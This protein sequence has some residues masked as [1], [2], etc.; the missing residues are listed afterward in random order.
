M[1]AIQ[2]F[3]NLQPFKGTEKE[4]FDEFLRQ[5]ESCTQVAG[6]PNDQRHRYLHLHLKGGALTFFDQQEAAVRND[7]DAAVAALRNRYQNDQR[8][9]LQKILQFTQNESL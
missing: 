9:Q 6:I 5:L 2:P 4:N 8:I 7:Y 3:V 1:A